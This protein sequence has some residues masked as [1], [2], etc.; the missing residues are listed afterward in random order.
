M[1][2]EQKVVAL[3]QEILGKTRLLVLNSNES[4][5]HH[6]IDADVGYLFV[7]QPTWV[8]CGCCFWLRTVRGT[9]TLIFSLNTSG[10]ASAKTSRTV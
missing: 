10:R 8:L 3:I 5:G 4:V 9:P 1:I 7:M 6:F 2:K